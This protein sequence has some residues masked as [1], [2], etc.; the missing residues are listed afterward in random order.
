VDD[1]GPGVANEERERLFDR[2]VRLSGPPPDVR[3]A[4]LGLTISRSIVRLHGGRIFAEASRDLAGLAIIVEIPTLAKRPKTTVPSSM[5][6]RAMP[7]T[8]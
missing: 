8:A 4:G 6:E 1:D 3:G 2:F 5:P 7:A